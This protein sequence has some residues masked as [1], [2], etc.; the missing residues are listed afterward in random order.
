MDYALEFAATLKAES[1]DA[2]L[3]FFKGAGADRSEKSRASFAK[4]KGMAENKISSLGLEFHS[5]RHGYIYPVTPRKEPNLMYKITR[6]FYPLIRMVGS[7]TSIKSKELARA[8]F[9]VGLNG[10]DQEVLENKTILEHL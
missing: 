9:T 8:M 5:F 1:P 3:C 4:Y 7:N 2:R 6:F 10:T